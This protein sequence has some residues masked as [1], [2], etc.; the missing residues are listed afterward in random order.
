MTKRCAHLADSVP[1]KVA[2][3]AGKMF[4]QAADGKAAAVRIR[5]KEEI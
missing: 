2:S 4:A 1:Q 3:A 5:Q